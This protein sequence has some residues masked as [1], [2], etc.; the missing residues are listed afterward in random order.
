V[1]GYSDST[2]STG[3]ER[4]LH[5]KAMILR[6]MKNLATRKS[7]NKH[8]S[9]VDVTS[10]NKIGKKRIRDLTGDVHIVVT[11]KYLV[12]RPIK[13][14]ILAKAMT[15]FPIYIKLNSTSLQLNE[16]F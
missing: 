5:R 11:F 7:S 13:S 10:L 4:S 1:T 2:R 14:E 12:Q 9:F 15:Q 8:G 6:L 3:H 16:Q